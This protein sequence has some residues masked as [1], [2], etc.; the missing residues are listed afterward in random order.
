MLLLALALA[1]GRG[2]GPRYLAA[3]AAGLVL[4]LAG[5]VF[6]ML[7]RD[8]F[9]AGLASFLAAH[10]AYVVAFTTGVSPD[11]APLLLAPAALPGAA[12]LAVLWPRLGRLR[13]AVTAYVAVITLMAW[14]AGTR[15][16]ALRSPAAVMAA[17]GAAC[18]V[19]SDAML[20]LDRFRAPFRSARGLV[21]GT[22]V[23][24]Q[25]LIASSVG[26]APA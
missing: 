6:L 11:S 15:A 10:L 19:A 18:F 13:P 20:A 1:A 8:R 23:A 17:L 9:V 25:W 26:A 14:Q 21:T 22:Y 7:P 12:V 5:D 4:S 24:A 3:V 16:W 2:A